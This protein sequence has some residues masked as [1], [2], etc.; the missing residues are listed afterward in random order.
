VTSASLLHAGCLEASPTPAS[1][2][3][4]LASPRP[5]ARRRA[6]AQLPRR[7]QAGPTN[8]QLP[9]Q[10]VGERVEVASQLAGPAGA[11]Y[12]PSFQRAGRR[13]A[14]RVGSRGSQPQPSAP[15]QGVRR[16]LPE[17]LDSD[18][19]PSVISFSPSPDRSGRALLLS[20]AD[21]RPHSA[22][23]P[24]RSERPTKDQS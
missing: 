15:A 9:E 4:R 8:L 11:C 23:A 13:S 10:A 18:S 22:P 24:S 16:V 14:V 17:P 2:A 1:S 19:A 3:K 21:R 6:E 20:F 5:A 7:G 12:P